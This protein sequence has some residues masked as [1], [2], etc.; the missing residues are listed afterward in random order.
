MEINSKKAYEIL[1]NGKNINPTGSWVEH[2]IRVG[3]A[4][5]RIAKKIGIDSDKAA[6][7]GYLH[8]IGK[9]YGEPYSQHVVKGYEYLKS[10]GISDEY[11]NICLTHSYLNND[12]NCTAGGIPD[13]DSYKYQFRKDFI[14]NHQYNIYDKIIKCCDLFCTA[15]FMTMDERLIEIMLR[16]GAH[17]NTVYH[18]TYAQKLKKE[19][20]E[21]MGCNLYSLFPE[22][23]KRFK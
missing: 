12:I 2:S 1:M 20:E 17:D 21:K 8:D 22:I 7:M 14:E 11:A 18:I 6:A 23:I 13:K 3:Q 10:M 15:Q 9:I 5:E 4:A 16:K 19:L